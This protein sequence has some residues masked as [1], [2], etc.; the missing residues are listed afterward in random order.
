MRQISCVCLHVTMSLYNFLFSRPI[1]CF[2]NV[3]FSCSFLFFLDSGL[4]EPV[5]GFHSFLRRF[6]VLPVIGGGVFVQ[7]VYLHTSG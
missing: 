1:F 6:F 4:T 5:L 7:V 2:F 3:S